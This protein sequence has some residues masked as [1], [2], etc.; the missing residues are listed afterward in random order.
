MYTLIVTAVGGS[1]VNIQ[2]PFPADGEFSEYVGPGDTE[3]FELL[4]AQYDRIV[5][6]LDRMVT[7]GLITYSA[8]DGPASEVINDSG[9]PGVTVKDALDNLAGGI[10]AD[11]IFSFSAGRAGATI[12]NVYLRGPG[13]VPT[14]LAGYIIPLN[15]TIFSLSMGSAGPY[16]WT[17]EIRKNNSV[18]V[19]TS[20]T[21]LGTEER[22][23]ATVS[24]DVDAGDEL[25]FYCN[26]TNV[27]APA[28]SIYLRR[29]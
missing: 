29:R 14:N 24:V 12:S 17:L 10:T 25:Q 28:G 11:E 18:T 1:G 22:K 2:D 20:L 19:L 6:L 7:L 8:L 21:T 15:G 5:G 3:T 9:V 13:G 27:P 26:G 4:D 16:A 23:Y